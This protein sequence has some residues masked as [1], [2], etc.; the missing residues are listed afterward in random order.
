MSPGQAKALPFLLEEMG[1]RGGALSHFAP[2]LGRMGRA[3]NSL[4]LI[5]FIQKTPFLPR[6]P[7][8]WALQEQRNHFCEDPLSSRKAFNAYDERLQG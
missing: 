5:L 3:P 6:S 8:L 1:V 2:S 4:G 7:F